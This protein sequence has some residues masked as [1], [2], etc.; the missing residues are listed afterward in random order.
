MTPKEKAKELI[1]KFIMH[2]IMVTDLFG[3]LSEGY[4]EDY[5]KKCALICVDE[6]IEMLEK[7]CE[8]PILGAFANKIGKSEILK[9]KKVKQEIEKL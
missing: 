2:N 1:D 3:R 6:K 9:L 5:Y 7:I 4:D 8:I